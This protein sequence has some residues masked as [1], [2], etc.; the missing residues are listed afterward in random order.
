MAAV[1][2]EAFLFIGHCNQL[3]VTDVSG[4]VSVP[5]VTISSHI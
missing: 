1:A 4:T 3:K 2:K 5:V